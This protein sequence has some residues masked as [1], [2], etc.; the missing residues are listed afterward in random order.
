MNTTHGP[1]DVNDM[2]QL[3]E[4]YGRIDNNHV[5]TYPHGTD[6]TIAKHRAQYR[7]DRS[8]VKLLT[9]R[10]RQQMASPCPRRNTR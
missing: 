10:I 2:V 6:E 4:A 8:A 9:S 1:V 7:L 3:R 5:W